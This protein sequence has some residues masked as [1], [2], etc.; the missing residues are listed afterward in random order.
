MTHESPKTRCIQHTKE[1][2]A[3]LFQGSWIGRS[4]GCE[5]PAHVWEIEVSFRWLNLKTRWEGQE[6]SHELM[7]Y[8]IDDQPAF[9]LGDKIATLLDSQHFIIPKWDTNDIRG[10]KGRSYDVVFSRPGLAELTADQAYADWKKA[11]KKRS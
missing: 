8:L 1:M 4:M 9:R 11:Q 2:N 6:K 7:G 5:S 10:G 3:Q